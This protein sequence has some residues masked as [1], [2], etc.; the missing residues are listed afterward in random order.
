M[1]SDTG[2]GTVPICLQCCDSFIHNIPGY[3]VTFTIL[4]STGMLE[5]PSW[6]LYYSLEMVIK[7]AEHSIMLTLF[8]SSYTVLILK[9]TKLVSSLQMSNKGIVIEESLNQ[10]LH[11][12]E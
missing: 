6:S 4:M 8:A 10:T 2:F 9:Y 11:T 12:E 1:K 7:Y 5:I 3:E